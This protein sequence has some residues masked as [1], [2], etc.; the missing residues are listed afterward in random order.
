MGIPHYVSASIF[1]VAKE[2]S[3]A[4]FHASVKLLA[5]C[6]FSYGITAGLRGYLFSILNTVL[7]QRLRWAPWH[8]LLAERVKP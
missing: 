2:G 8:P 7:I 5:L 4:R 1:A 6:S 3:A